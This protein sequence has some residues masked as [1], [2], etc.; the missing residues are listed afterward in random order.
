MF[1]IAKKKS[2]HAYSNS[3]IINVNFLRGA[4]VKFLQR[5]YV[6]CGLNL[7]AILLSEVDRAK[8]KLGWELRLAARFERPVMS[9]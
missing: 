1:Y 7:L 9:K 8:G 2:P 3:N 4:K 5:I 6:I